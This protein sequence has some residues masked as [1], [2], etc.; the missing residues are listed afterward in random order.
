MY[1]YIHINL[2]NVY[3]RLYCM[4]IVYTIVY[5]LYTMYISSFLAIMN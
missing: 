1:I 2:V 4:Y 3:F 5:I